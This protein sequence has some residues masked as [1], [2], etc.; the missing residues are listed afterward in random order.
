M[1]MSN[2]QLH[3]FLYKRGLLNHQDELSRHCF[4]HNSS[5]LDIV[6]IQQAC[7]QISLLLFIQFTVIGV[8]VVNSIMSASCTEY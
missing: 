7:C 5:G 2:E 3:I 4:L 8:D 1:T 6:W